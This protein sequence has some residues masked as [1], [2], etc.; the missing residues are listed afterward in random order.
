MVNLYGGKSNQNVDKLR[1]EL[2]NRTI[3]KSSLFTTF[4]LESLPPTSN[5]LK[6]HSFRV[7]HAVQGALGI[8]LSA[9]EWGWI[10]KKGVLWPIMTDREIS[11]EC[12]L[13]LI[14]CGCK[15]YCRKASTC[16]CRRFVIEC[17]S[18]CSGCNGLNCSNTYLI[19]DSNEEY[20]DTML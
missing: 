15:T 6:Q 5:A 14:S 7:Y 12:L 11:P 9:V 16:T 17:C 3:R 10:N 2:Y 19:E 20:T 1:Y 8:T 4:K 18:L 13:K